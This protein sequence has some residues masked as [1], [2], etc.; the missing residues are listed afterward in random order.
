[1]KPMHAG[2]MRR[3]ASLIAAGLAF[4]VLSI[5]SAAGPPLS[6]EFS[7]SREELRALSAPLPQEIR[8]RIIAR[9]EAFLHLLARLMDEPAMLLVLVDKSHPL[10]SDYAPPDLVRL[11]KDYQLNVALNDVPVR[12]AIMP[13]MLEMVAAARADGVTLTFTS[14]FRSFDYQASVYAR[15]VKMYGQKTA[16]R[17]SARPGTSQHQLGT[18]IDF[19]SISDAFADTPEGKWLAAHAGEYGFSLSYPPGYELLTGYRYESWHYRFITKAG[20]QMQKE[21]F[22]DIQ[23]YLLAFLHEHRAALEAKRLKSR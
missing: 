12:L 5:A 20:A 10:A 18:A 15:E 16:D 1:M 23:Q 4:A 3:I 11:H 8:D 17:E 21:F 6:S 7:L 14:G 19:G 13:A 22:G 2:I 9:P